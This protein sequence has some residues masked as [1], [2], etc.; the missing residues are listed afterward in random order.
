MIWAA[1]AIAVVVAL[2]ACNPY[3]TQQSLAPPGRAARLDEITNVWGVVK[4]YR[5]ELSEGVA[6]AVSC[7]YAGPCE[8]L[9]I[10]SRDPAI[11]EV[12]PASFGVLLP[13]GVFNAQSA[14]ALVV[15]GR[16][17]G[18]TTLHVKANQG[19]RDIIVTVV[20]PP[21]PLQNAALAADAR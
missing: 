14:S 2:S 7:Y 9:Q 5:M 13:A 11:A 1:I 17:P 4:R 3:L 19:E 15:V 8:H 18:T 16:A 21:S 10:T 6:M 12:R 20:A